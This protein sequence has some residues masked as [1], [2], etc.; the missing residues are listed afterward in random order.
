MVRI[1]TDHPEFLNDIADVIRL[2]LHM[3]EVIPAEENQ[4]SGDEVFISAVMELG[5]DWRAVCRCTAP[6]GQSEYV[7]VHPAVEG[8]ELVRKRY[9]KRC[10]KIGVFRAMAKLFDA[11]LPWGSLTYIR[12]INILLI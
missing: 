6:D 7:Y 3:E 11:N 10:L 5:E 1:Y 12:A 9:L 2:Y 4:R 8:G